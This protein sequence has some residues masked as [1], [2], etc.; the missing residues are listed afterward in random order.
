MIKEDQK[1]PQEASKQTDPKAPQTDITMIEVEAITVAE[2]IKTALKTLN[3][4]KQ[5]V[6]IEVLKEEHMGLF[7]M[8]GAEK[9]KIRV[10]LKNGD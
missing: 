4:K 1:Q 9:A 5:E 2:A 7:G 10:K 6:T 3:A 8:E